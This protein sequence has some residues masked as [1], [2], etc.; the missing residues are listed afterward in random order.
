MM[1]DFQN[2][3][4]IS[5]KYD[6]TDLFITMTAN[7]RQP[8]ILNALLPGQASIDRQDVMLYVFHQK[9]VF[10]IDLIIKKDVLGS[11]VNQIHTIKFQKRSAT[12]VSSHMTSI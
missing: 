1:E 5:R 10:L 3:L 8:E 2:S 11:T 6:V 7:L 4:T 12:H 9:K